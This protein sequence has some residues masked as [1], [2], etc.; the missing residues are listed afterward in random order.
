MGRSKSV[1]SIYEEAKMDQSGILLKRLFERY[2]GERIRHISKWL[3]S[4]AHKKI[5]EI[6]IW[7]EDWFPG[8]PLVVNQAVV[9]GKRKKTR[10]RKKRR[11]KRRRT[12]KKK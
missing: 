7:R 5:K 3:E 8:R 10:R 12:R 4:K 1:N 6:P 2:E 9:G 11:R